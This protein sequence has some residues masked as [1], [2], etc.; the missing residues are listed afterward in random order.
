M[1]R[2][3]VV[4]VVVLVWA[5]ME[6]SPARAEVTAEQVNAAIAN[7]VAYL[8]K[9]QQ[10]GGNWSEYTLE[11]GGVTALCTLALLNC[12]RTPAD[13]SVKKGLDYLERMQDPDRIYSVALTLMAF[14]Q[15]DPKK[16]ALKIKQRAMWIEAKQ[17]RG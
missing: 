1:L 10:P 12:G 14:A 6:V 15:A 3:R 7:G 5:A 9:Q 13:A 16:Y 11:P 2:K 4:L 17:I 8:E